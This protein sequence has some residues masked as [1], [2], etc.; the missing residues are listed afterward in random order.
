MAKTI[1]LSSL[2]LLTISLLFIGCQ[3]NVKDHTKPKVDE[4]LVNKHLL[5]D[6]K[7]IAENG[8]INVVI[9]IPAGTLEKCEVDKTSGDLSL[10]EI[11]GKPRI[12]QYLAYPA[13][14]G[15]IPQTYLPKELGGDGDPLDVIVLGDASEK[16]S[17]IEC[18]LIGIMKMVD[19]GEQDDKLIAVKI[20]SP[21][22]EINSIKELNTQFKGVCVILETWFENYKGPNKVEVMGFEEKEFA[23]N[24]LQEAINEYKKK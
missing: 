18:K 7:P 11:D 23:E 2:F 8:N 14:Y 21:F 22:N 3:Y 10:E 24:I 16:G 20:D 12:V 15:M 19:R 4:T 5:H 13:N 9:E 17:V 1:K 6:Y